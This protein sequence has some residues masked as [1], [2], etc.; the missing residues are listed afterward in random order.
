MFA[1]QMGEGRTL[2]IVDEAGERQAIADGIS[3]TG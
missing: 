3:E 2:Q 1:Y